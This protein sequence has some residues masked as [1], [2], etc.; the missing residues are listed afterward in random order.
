MIKNEA[1]RNLPP[2]TSVVLRDVIHATW[3]YDPNKRM[4]LDYVRDRLR[5]VTQLGPLEWKNNETWEA[6]K[7][8]TCS[9]PQGSDQLYR[10]LGD[11]PN[12]FKIDPGRK[13]S[14]FLFAIETGQVAIVEMLLHYARSHEM[15]ESVLDA[16][17][18]L[19]ESTPLHWAV[20]G[21]NPEVVTM[22]LN[23]HHEIPG[24]SPSHALTVLTSGGCS[25][26]GVAADGGRSGS[27]AA[28]LEYARAHGILEPI[29]DAKNGANQWTALHAASIEGTPETVIMLLNAHLEILGRSPLH[30]LMALTGGGVT[31]LWC[32]AR[33]G[34]NDVV[35]VI[36]EYARANGILEPIL[37]AKNGTD[38][39][40][41]LHEACAFGNPEI[42]AMLLNAHL[43]ILG[44]P[45]LQVL[46]TP[47]SD[48]GS[49]CLRRARLGDAAS[50]TRERAGGD[51][52][53]EACRP[54]QG[55][56]CELEEEVEDV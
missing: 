31:P 36:L 43:E 1:V 11:I 26:L 33:G 39:W 9:D 32:A 55:V 7:N 53:E 38:Q 44:R 24:R 37:D 28:I 20:R 10:A 8:W 2:E 48:Q 5:G 49:V 18:G 21:G 17:F 34:R 40:T 54:R 42:I 27:I 4:S 13:K 30:V 6:I 16:K 23:A 15:L 46:T 50:A 22:L 29:L 51:W 35:A 3:D 19:S 41:A 56:L 47:T 14:F 52:S 12:P 45:P 25:P